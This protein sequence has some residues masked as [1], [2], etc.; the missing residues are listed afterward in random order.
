[1]KANKTSDAHKLKDLFEL[2]CLSSLSASTCSH[3]MKPK[4]P[5][6]CAQ[7][8]EPFL[9]GGA[10]TYTGVVGIAEGGV[11]ELAAELSWKGIFQPP[12][13]WHSSHSN[14]LEGILES[15]YPHM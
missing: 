2:S 3:V 15:P 10:L 6:R 4:K 9:Q 7:A 8:F 11:R 5:F 1:M 12:I 13:E 14:L